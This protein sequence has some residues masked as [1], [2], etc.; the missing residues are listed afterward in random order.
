MIRSFD[1]LK[2][3]N[4]NN[5]DN[6]NNNNNNNNKFLTEATKNSGTKNK[7]LKIIFKMRDFLKLT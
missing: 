7:M 3:N 5:N 2:N 1:K 6:N 4:D